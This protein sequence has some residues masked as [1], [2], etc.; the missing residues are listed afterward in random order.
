MSPK[1]R[2]GPQSRSCRTRSAPIDRAMPQVGGTPALQDAFL[3]GTIT[4]DG[5]GIARSS[6]ELPDV[7]D[8]AFIIVPD[9]TA[10]DPLFEVRRNTSTP[11][12]ENAV[13]GEV[14]WAVC[15]RAQSP[16]GLA[17]FHLDLLTPV[18]VSTSLVL[19]ADLFTDALRVAIAGGLIALLDGESHRHLFTNAD[20]DYTEFL[21]RAV[22]ISVP[23]SR[24]LPVLL[25][26]IA[27]SPR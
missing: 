7:P 24:T 18:P 26:H 11:D 4:A 9:G 16:Y 14:G 20:T 27:I 25:D 17:K 2:S 1:R 19:I 6:I 23:P 21:D 8:M 13:Y 5:A 22:L 12:W 15:A 3:A 10:L